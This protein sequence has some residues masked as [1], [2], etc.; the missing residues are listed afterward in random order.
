MMNGSIGIWLLFGIG[1]HI[2][3]HMLDI[4]DYM[5]MKIALLG[6]DCYDE[7]VLCI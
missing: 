6:M 1:R 4:S 3:R 2:I 7:I 5:T